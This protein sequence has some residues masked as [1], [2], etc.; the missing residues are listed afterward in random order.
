VEKAYGC[1]ALKWEEEVRSFNNRAWAILLGQNYTKFK[2]LSL[3]DF[4]DLF[5]GNKILELIANKSNQY[6]MAKFETSAAILAD[7]IRVFV[8]ILILSGYNTVPNYKLYW[9]NSEDMEN[10]LIKQAMS[11]DRF[12]MIKDSFQL[13]TVR[14]WWVTV[15][16]R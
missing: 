4:F 12:H 8:A 11:R 10:K 1:L 6:C 3:V 13:G 16:R 2:K 15:T 14:S 9:S 7:E 5:F